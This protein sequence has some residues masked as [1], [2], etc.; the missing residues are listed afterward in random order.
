MIIPGE[1]SVGE[2]AAEVFT[3]HLLGQKETG[4]LGS[5][6]TAGAAAP[7]RSSGHAG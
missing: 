3:E 4:A 1:L 7:P 5:N 2:L 6:P